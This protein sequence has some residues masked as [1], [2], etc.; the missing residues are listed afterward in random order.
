[1][2]ILPFLLI[3]V[4]SIIVSMVLHEMMHGYVSYWL[5]DDTALE[6]GRL[7]FNPLRHIDPFLTVL[8]PLFLAVTS[9]VTGASLPLFGAAKPVPFNPEK[10]KG[11]EWG[12]ALV[13]LAGPLTNLVLA[14]IVFG[15]W[16][17]VGTPTTGLSYQICQAF[18]F[19]NLGFFA[20]NLIPIPPLDGSR[21]LYAFAPDFI[22]RGM[23]IIERGGLMVILAIVL[24]ASTFITQLI[25][26]VDSAI[27]GLFNDFFS[28]F[29]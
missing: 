14:F 25:G 5:G 17:F 22:R 1:M 3:V 26:V 11:S 28:L 7:S 9:A 6:H 10:V 8:L 19:V 24:I 4:V 23:E 21:V 16:T 18:I 27:L 29:V 2:A 12:V 15:I 13:A 20:F